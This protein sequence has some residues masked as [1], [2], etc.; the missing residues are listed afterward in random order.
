MY[1]IYDLQAK[2]K[3]SIYELHIIITFPQVGQC[4]VGWY[5]VNYIGNIKTVNTITI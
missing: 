5:N 3:I 4:I 2:L 1:I